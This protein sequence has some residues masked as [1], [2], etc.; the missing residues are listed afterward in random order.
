MGGGQMAVTGAG[1]RAPRYALLKRA[2]DLILAT[3]LL[4]LTSPIIAACL[5][6]VWIGSGR[7][8]IHR[9]RVV[10]RLGRPFDSYKLRT[11][12]RDADELLMR[13]D[14]LH[15]AS[16]ASAK[17]ANDPRVTAVG[18]W[19]RR[20][21]L[22]ELPQLVN[23]LRGEMSLV[24]PRMLTAEELVAW[25][26]ARE[27]ILSVR[28]GITG[29]WQVSGRQTLTRADR[30]RLD[31]EYVRRMSLALDINILTRTLPAVLSGR[32]AL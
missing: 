30:I 31:S 21:S 28:P 3:L 19:L 25:G 17:V 24:G 22:D 12:V 6:I 26:P 9:R 32:G 20:T 16:I 1:V 10:G 2:L 27:I 13:N 7:P 5:A 29:L 11:M 15:N 23:V 8:L 4:A 14:A 18:R